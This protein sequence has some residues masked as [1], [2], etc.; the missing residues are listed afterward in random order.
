[1]TSGENNTTTD[2]AKRLT[3]IT[4]VS[5]FYLLVGLITAIVNTLSVALHLYGYATHGRQE[6]LYYLLLLI[7]GMISGIIAVVAG[8]GLWKLKRWAYQ[9]AIVISGL[10]ILISLFSL[11][12]IPIIFHGLILVGLF[13]K[14]VKLAFTSS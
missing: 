9:T 2:K 4:I 13:S 1:M 5:L 7:A 6:P 8:I 14:G 10:L 12:F 11:S 3:T